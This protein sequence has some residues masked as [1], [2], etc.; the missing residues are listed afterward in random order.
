MVKYPCT[1]FEKKYCRILFWWK[2]QF[3]AYLPKNFLWI[4]ENLSQTQRLFNCNDISVLKKVNLKYGNLAMTC[5]KYQVYLYGSEAITNLNDF[6]WVVTEPA[7]WVIKLPPTPTTGSPPPSL[8][9]G[10][11]FTHLEENSSMVKLPY[12]CE[13]ARGKPVCLRKH[14]M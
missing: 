1:D 12:L 7:L 2:I 3:F 9:G 11:T 8:Y 10:I 14:H 4:K 6:L 13:K 5:L